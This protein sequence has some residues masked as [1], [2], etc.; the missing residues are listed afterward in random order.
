MEKNITTSRPS[1]SFNTQFF[2]TRIQLTMAR[3]LRHTYM[4]GRNEINDHTDRNE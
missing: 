1:T 2:V 3:T 4:K